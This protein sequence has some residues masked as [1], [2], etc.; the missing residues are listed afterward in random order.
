ME[1][2]YLIIIVFLFL[3]ASFDLWV[4]VS[5]D[6]VNFLNSA[7]GARVARYRTIM[8]VA[9]LGVLAGALLSNGMMDIARHGIMNPSNFTF[10]EVM[11]ILLAVMVTDVVILDMFNS[12]GLPT[13]TTVSM[14]FELLG[15][16]FLM[17]MLKMAHGSELQIFDLMNTEKALTVIIAIFVSV[18]IAFVFGYIVQWVSRLI[19]TF[20]YKEN[21]RYT[22]AIFG[23]IAVTAL[24]Y[25]VFAKGLGG[26]WFIDKS[27]VNFIDTHIQTLLI[28][29]FVGSTVV[30]E[31]LHLCKVNI[32][33]FI[34]LA[35]TFALAMAFAGNDLVNFIG[36]PL[37]G[38]SSF[39]DYMVHGGGANDSFMM[40][41]LQ[42]SAK[43]PMLYLSI[44]AFIMIFSMVTS[45]KARNVIKTSVDLSRQ[46]EGDEMFG[47]S[48][49]ARSIARLTQNYSE[50]MERVIP[51]PVRRWIDGRFDNQ[52]VALAPGVAFDEVRASVNLVLAA[53]L[54][55]IGT[56]LKLPLSTTYV[57]FMVAMSSSLADRAWGRE[58]AVFR[59]TGMLS[60]IG[61]W[62]V[63]AG[64]AFLG[65]ML[66][67]LIMFYGGIAAMIVFM[68]LVV[69]L[70]IRS[71]KKFSDS[72]KGNKE[73][74]L[75]KLMMRSKD[76]EIVWDL[77]V[78]H[79][80]RVQSD[81]TNF[82][83][84]QYTRIFEGLSQRKISELRGSQNALRKE[85][86]M[87]KK[88]RKKEILVMHRAP[89]EL[90]M[91]RNTWFHL[92]ANSAQQYIYCLKRMLEP[93]KEHV[94]NNFNPLPQSYIEE[95][96]PIL[97]SIHQLMKQ[98]AGFISTGRYNGYRDVMAEA[99]R[100]KNDLSMLRRKHID[101][102]QQ[103]RNSKNLQI[104]IV[105]LN[106]IQETQELLSV[107]RHQLRATRKF[108]GAPGVSYSESE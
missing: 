27:V 29:V 69:Y 32:F 12:L 63:T 85:Q 102:M 62:F 90:A 49:A 33:R 46:D 59:I 103:D 1:L 54:I 2:I 10:H 108:I 44:A 81:M 82:A 100:C 104:S 58:S 23:G 65:C 101:R 87:L 8:I 43:T 42:G 78:K 5:N 105:Y 37:A 98:S 97:N 18:A 61:G 66:V 13:S 70:L 31:I 51:Q 94:D 41:S 92:G 4:G 53:L 80:S 91:E 16:T 60:V 76:P 21:L 106:L 107:M 84:E 93:I 73:D 6:A 19:F 34:I 35:G 56:N 88:Y 38:L 99:D 39:Q 9:S 26:A 20:K 24:S 3:L 77:L 15:G 96:Q 40:E 25:F 47:T 50:N 95:F 14:V 83:L 89:Q 71:S 28:G 68:G 22:V 74:E 11:V 17:A 48:R 30:M 72:E 36:V 79:V 64:V 55:I 45:K 67:T 75:F 52:G 57:T 86:E 7:V